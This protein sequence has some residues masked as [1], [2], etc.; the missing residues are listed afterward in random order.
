MKLVK[1]KR[2]NWDEIAKDMGNRNSKMCYSRYRR[3]SY[4][5]KMNWMQKE[6]RLILSYVAEYGEKWNDLS[7]L[8]KSKKSYNLDRS[9]KQIQQH[10]EFCLNPKVNKSYWTIEEDLLLVELL[11]KYGNDWKGI[12]K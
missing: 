8:L 5:A 10:Y 2:K 11:E 6:E 9:A 1:L 12:E 4:S 3:L 7:K